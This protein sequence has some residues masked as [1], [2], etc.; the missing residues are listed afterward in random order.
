MNFEASAPPFKDH[1]T[2]SSA[3]NVWTAVKFSFTSLELDEEPA[4]PEGPVIVGAISS[5][6]T[7]VTGFL[8]VDLLPILY[9]WFIWST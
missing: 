8:K 1:V 7:I 3:E 5:I 6:F 9:S 4:P 2:V